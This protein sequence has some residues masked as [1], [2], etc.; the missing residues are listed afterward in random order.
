MAAGKKSRLGREK[1]DAN[2]AKQAERAAEAKKEERQATEMEQPSSVRPF[3]PV[4]NGFEAEGKA[5]IERV[6]Y[7]PF[8]FLPYGFNRF[9]ACFV[10]VKHTVYDPLRTRRIFL[11]G[12]YQTG[13]KP[14]L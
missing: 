11:T 7:T 12:Q 8:V 6:T 10:I 1:M 2:A 5:Q 9:P 13:S 3:Y 4:E 14:N